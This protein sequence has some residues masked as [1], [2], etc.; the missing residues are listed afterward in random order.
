MEINV[1]NI[2]AIVLSFL[3]M[4]LATYT[5]LLW[6]EAK[7]TR[8]QNLT[9]QISLT[10]FPFAGSV[11]G[12]M[13]VNTGKSDAVCVNIECVNDEIYDFKNK[14]FKYAEKLTKQYS[15][16]PVNQQYKY[17][18]GEYECLKNEYFQFVI[19]FKDIS[20]K[21]KFEYKISFDMSQMKNSLIGTKHEERIADSLDKISKKIDGIV[22]SDGSNAIR[23]YTYPQQYREDRSF[24]QKID[25]I[26][27]LLIELQNDVSEIKKDKN[28]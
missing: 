18:I 1:I 12:M 20:L 5:A 2:N 9:P 4:V 26:Q 15:Y 7:K 27:E 21:Y 28:R 25:D 16:F 8:I 17:I 22:T 24:S 19:S 13:I 10:F 11:I 6:M 23:C 3:T 14:N